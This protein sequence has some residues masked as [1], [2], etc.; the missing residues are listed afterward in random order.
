[1]LPKSRLIKISFWRISITLIIAIFLPTTSGNLVI[2]F[3]IINCL[4]MCRFFAK[5][6]HMKY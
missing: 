1:M 3:V 6:S 2:R 4:V 5:I